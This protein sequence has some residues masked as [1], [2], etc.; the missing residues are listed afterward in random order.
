LS[1]IDALSDCLTTS[2]DERSESGEALPR[3]LA[4][5]SGRAPERLELRGFG[6][7]RMGTATTLALEPGEIVALLGPTGSGKTSLL[8]AMLGL[9]PALGRLYY[10]GRDLSAAGIGP[11]ERPL[12]W[13][14][15]EAPL[16]ADTLLGNVGLFSD[17]RRARQ[18]LAWIG[19]DRLQRELADEKLGPGGRP[20]SGGERRLVS[21]A[22]ALAT[23]LPVLLLDEPTEGLDPDAAQLVIAALTKLER[24]RTLLIVTHRTDVAA[25]ADRTVSVGEPRPR[26]RQP[27]V[28]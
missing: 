28:A 24:R 21:V 27:H 8:R 25:I 2:P 6:A 23:G 10:G 7:R 9:E 16:V 18:A 4:G 13:V 20:L 17:E 22:R 1:A 12:A 15:Q 3:A 19:A 5:S 26:A 11:P 14:P